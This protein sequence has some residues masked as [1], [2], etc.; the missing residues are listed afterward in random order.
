MPRTLL[1]ITLKQGSIPIV[2]PPLPY[3]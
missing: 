3:R 2:G 1:L